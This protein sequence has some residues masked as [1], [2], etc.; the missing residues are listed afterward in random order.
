[1]KRHKAYYRLVLGLAAWALSWCFIGSLGAVPTTVDPVQ[2][3]KAAL[4]VPVDPSSEDGLRF[5]KASLEEQAKALSVADLRRALM[6]QEWRDEDPEE[7]LARIDREVRDQLIKRLD[8]IVQQ[9]LA[10]SNQATQLAGI[11][12]VAEMGINLRGAGPRVPLARH[13]G[14]TLVKLM[15]GSDARVAEAAALA[16]G[17]ISPDPE[18]AGKALA[19]MLKSKN[20]S[21]RR[22]AAQSMES[23]L[24]IL[25][26]RTKTSV[27]SAVSTGVVI[28]HAEI[29]AAARAIVPAAV[30][31]VNDSDRL[32]QTNCLNAIRLAAAMF[33]DLVVIPTRQEFPPAGRKPSAAEVEQM[34]AFRNEVKR[35]REM[36]VPLAEELNKQVPLLA[37]MLSNNSPAIRVQVARTLKEIGY[38][39]QRLERKAATVPQAPMAKAD[40][41]TTNADL[42]HLAQ[43]AGHTPVEEGVEAADSP[44][45]KIWDD[46]LLSGLKGAMPQLVGR[47]SDPNLEVRLA[48]VE[49]LETLGT[50]AGAAVKPV[51]GKA[52][53]DENRFVRWAAARFLA[54][55]G[56]PYTTTPVAGL[57]RR[58]SDTDLDVRIASAHTLG[59]YGAVGAASVPALAM[60][61]GVGDAEVREAAI[62]ALQSI[63]RDQAK[64]VGPAV[65]ALAEALQFSD[66]RVR[67]AAAEALGQLGPVARSA[68]GALQ[69]V[70]NDSNAE[71]RG[72]VADAL[73]S[74]MAEK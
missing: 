6:L 70:A 45:D 42:V 49:T 69:K 28:P 47:L 72:A 32:V 71:V 44:N 18:L 66:A 21:M 48:S 14:P 56:P 15:Q 25:V 54:K 9:S 3:L 17:K 68:A 67:R 38:A 74:V 41:G 16:L 52:L 73:L 12:Q 7:K 22:A 59:D 4:T 26:S 23:M 60:A 2:A 8:G 34:K 1:M 13:F 57:A 30:K 65:P 11:D 64:L 19:T 63:G 5:R 39:R 40:A 35:E 31:G 50:N 10:S 62:K 46:P 58:M 37:G 53:E 36:L 33:S 29:V 43:L 24:Q 55:V 51:A 61:A 27:T 20:A